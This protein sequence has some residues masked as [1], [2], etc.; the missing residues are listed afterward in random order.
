MTGLFQFLNELGRFDTDEF[1]T[2]WAFFCKLNDT[3]CFREESMVFTTANVLS[4]MKLGTALSYYD[5]SS[6][7]L[8]ATKQFN[9]K[10]LRYGIATV[11]STTACFFMCHKCPWLSLDASN[12]HFS[13]Q[14]TMPLLLFI[15]LTAIEFDDLNLVASTL[16]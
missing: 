11:I 8:L 9:T 3:I 10:A 5:V 14:L 16:F 7:N 6:F 4:W 1:S 2:M 12:L 13:K 15:M